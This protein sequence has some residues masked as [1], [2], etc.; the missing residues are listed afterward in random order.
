MKTTPN[1]FR[2]VLSIAMLAFTCM[3][4]F[5][6]NTVYSQAPAKRQN[7]SQPEHNAEL[8][9]M[10]VMSIAQDAKGFLWIATLKGLNKYDGNA[11]TQYYESPGGIPSNTVMT[12]LATGNDV[13]IGTDKGLCI[14]DSE[15]D[16][17]SYFDTVDTGEI[18]SIEQIGETKIAVGAENGLYIVDTETMASEK[19]GDSV[20]FRLTADRYGSIW[21][22]TQ[23]TVK[24]YYA[25]GKEKTIAYDNVP[26]NRISPS[27]IYS[28]SHGTI[29]LGTTNDGI[30]KYDKES[31]TF[32]P[33]EM[34]GYSKQA[35]KY[36]R[37]M[38]EDLH[39][40]LWIGTENGLFIH[41]MNAGTCEHYTKDKKSSASGSI[42][43]NALY[44]IFLSR[45]GI[46]WIGTFFGGVNCTNTVNPHFK[47]I[48]DRDGG[49]FLDGA[50][51]SHIFCDSRK[52]MWFATENEGV[53]VY[54]MKTRDARALNT[55]T[56]PG[57]T[58]NNTHAIAEDPYGNIWIGNFV[59]GLHCFAPDLD[60]GPDVFLAG[61]GK[62]ALPDNSVYCLLAD[63]KDSLL[64][65]MVSG[66]AV[67][68]YHTGRFYRMGQDVLNDE[69]ID[70]IHRDRDG[71]I[72]MA[73]HFNGI[74]RYS[75]ADH[76]IHHYS[77]MS[78]KRMSSDLI[79][80]CFED[81]AGDL[82]FG[83]NNG[84]ILKYDK[85]DNDI[86]SFGADDVL[87]QRDIYFIEED[88]FGNLWLS[89]DRGIYSFDPESG[90]FNH[91]KLKN[92]DVSN[93]FNYNSGYKNPSQGTIY[94]GS[95]NGACYFQPEEIIMDKTENSPEIVFSDFKI[96]N[97]SIAPGEGSVLKQSIDHT[98][99]IV[100]KYN[101]N[102]ISV[103][104]KYI[105]FGTFMPN[106]F[107]C[108]Y[109]LEN[110]DAEW[111]PAGNPQICNYSKLDP[112]KYAFRTR[113]VDKNGN[114]LEDRCVRIRI[115]PHL[116]LSPGFYLIYTLLGLSLL[117]LGLKIS[118][119]RMND[120]L[121]LKI[122]QIE[123]QNLETI[124][125]HRINF[126]TYISHEFKSPL[127]ILLAIME[128]I[129]KSGNERKISPQETEIIS[130]NTRRL[131]FLINQLMEF[132]S[133]ETNHEKM[134]YIKGDIVNFCNKIFEMFI[135]LFRQNNLR[136][137]FR[138]SHQSFITAFDND[139]IE[140]IIS[141]L[142]SNAVKHSIPAEH[143]ISV[144]FGISID[145]EKRSLTFSCH[146]M[147]S[148]ISKEQQ[149]T[150]LQPFFKTETTKAYNYNNGIGLA[151]VK[152]LVDLQKGKI[153]I[154]SDMEKGTTFIVTMPFVTA[155][156]EIE[157]SPIDS[158]NT[159][160]TKEIIGNTIYDV[161][162]LIQVQNEEIPGA[163]SDGQKTYTLLIVDDDVEIGQMLKSR[164]KGSYHIKRASNGIEALEIVR[165]TDIDMVIC[166]IFMPGM[167]GF[168]VCRRIKGNTKTRHI[169]VILMTSEDSKE[170]EIKGLQMGADEYLRKPFSIEEL[171]L[172]ITNLL[173]SKKSI[174][175]YY[176]SISN[177]IETGTNSS[178]RDENFINQI[179][180]VIVE[181]MSES[182]LNV[183][184][185]ADSM[186]I[187][188]TKLYMR[189]K[190]ITGMSATEF[191]NKVKIDAAKEILMNNECTINEIAWKT[192]YNSPNYFSR[193][194]RKYA[195]CTPSEFIRKQKGL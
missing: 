150:I 98:S 56:R 191:V 21:A 43:D 19:V 162:N 13:W 90:T 4:S 10:S 85:Q 154:D 23:S 135:P 180:K 107:V 68:N 28:D 151:L 175:E 67:Y 120:K 159:K 163:A 186:N 15:T 82:W 189:L 62:Y 187:S 137:E 3:E 87:K 184:F 58:G 48:T 24:I 91:Y 32:V 173:N 172:R 97:N 195:G 46:M 134:N 38:N 178:N 59:D 145:E 111:I 188:R 41:D 113:V 130:H 165:N 167:N 31:A 51:V 126:F 192:G 168:E 14:Y 109:R 6:A 54:D 105:D 115:K 81:S 77:K 47:E 127:T 9:N 114:I 5:C 174:K 40:N 1:A 35:V 148:Y 112:G 139:K 122:E 94:L 123:K 79:F 103:E 75:P 170:S 63:N 153:V 171:N 118:R 121:A 53:Y 8:S 193:M 132:R 37:C 183:D 100:L 110:E 50:A 2:T 65:G 136:Y 176:N 138:T 190:S 106:S 164:L 161:K 20:V 7:F 179:T 95:I 143:E 181:N 84:G 125:R 104:F 141:N 177:N 69:R 169:P 78:H 45:E 25:N 131:I 80:C 149:E 34:P 117:L 101:E 129:E 140:K 57:L 44:T 61:S 116:L 27:T 96:H 42:N 119:N 39:G 124:N 155:N 92:S 76:E 86:L 18:C 72:W 142:L 194:F 29:W 70:D 182:N 33:Y 64:I 166:D 144:S 71:N 128:D 102:S 26:G 49:R 16:R 73:A 158:V 52:R 152:E 99:D 156:P 185:L 146:N 160:N 89:T 22:I 108:E 66:M 36:V 11:I 88:S 74:F 83:T 12:L 93:Q 17:F 147:G 157:I 133:I 55:E 60:K 30:Y